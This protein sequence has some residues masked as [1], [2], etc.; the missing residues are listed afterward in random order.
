MNIAKEIPYW[1]ASIYH[2]VADEVRAQLLHRSL[3]YGE[4]LLSGKLPSGQPSPIEDDKKAVVFHAFKEHFKE[5][6]EL[7]PADESVLRHGQALGNALMELDLGTKHGM[8]SEAIAEWTDGG[9]EP[10][11]RLRDAFHACRAKELPEKLQVAS[12]AL[13]KKTLQAVSD[14]DQFMQ[15][16]DVAPFETL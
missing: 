2:G 16:K 5:L 1:D 12:L 10:T 4:V 11:H 8:L 15:H 6:S 13:F 7:C 14:A 3:A 9:M